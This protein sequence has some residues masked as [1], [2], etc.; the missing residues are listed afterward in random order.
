MK[1]RT[2]AVAGYSGRRRPFGAAAETVVVPFDAGHDPAGPDGAARVELQAMLDGVADGITVQDAAGRLHYAN[3]AAARIIGFETAAELLATPVAKIMQRF[4]LADEHGNPISVLDL[5]GRKALAGEPAPDLLVRYRILA[6]GEERWGLTKARAVRDPDGSIRLAVNVFTDIT[7]MRIAL[8]EREEWRLVVEAAPDGMIGTDAGGR[9]VLVNSE[10]EKLFGVERDRLMGRPAS[11]LLPAR[12]RSFLEEARRAALDTLAESSIVTRADLEGLRGDGTE[13]PIAVA[14]GRMVTAR[15]VVLLG[16][17]RDITE[18]RAVEER[19]AH[20]AFHDALT[21]L[22]NR[23]MLEQHLARG[24]ERAARRKGAVGLLYVDLDEFK[25]VNDSLGH[26]AGDFLLRQVGERLSAL[27][28]G[29]DLLARPGGDEFLLLVDDL[30]GD[31]AAAAEAIAERI[32]AALRPPF[33]IEGTELR[34]GASV[35]VSLFPDDATDAD[36]LLRHAD[37]ALYAG[38]AAGRGR[39]VS[40]AQ[41]AGP[42]ADRLTLTTR[43]RRAVAHEEFVLHW[44]PIVDLTDGR[45]AGAEGLVRWQDPDRGLLPPGEFIEAAEGLGLIGAIGE[46]VLREACRQAAAWEHRLPVSIN[47]SPRQVREPG[48]AAR[49]VERL[50]EAGLDTSLFTLELTESAAAEEGTSALTDLANVGFTIA[51][52]DFG[53]G[54]SSLAR[55]SALPVRELKIDRSFVA[56]LGSDRRAEAVVRAIVDLARSLGLEAVAEGIETAEQLRTLR[57]LGCRRGQGYLLGRPVA[58]ADLPRGCVTLP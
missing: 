50:R 24:L 58:A 2:P 42:D 8:R 40:Y 14:F 55:L 18:R 19:I 47:L 6:T 4:E 31:P 13:F 38:K 7:E 21:G 27:T 48:L 12:H 28:R 32:H 33:P 25:M 16:T 49:M 39:S 1:P 43:L 57:A 37:A 5:P 17:V 41:L 51:I 23:A 35:G 56:A 53:T 20:L 26:L 30:G 9:I 22:P 3:D 11:D 10:A 45:V 34:I 52:D 54:Y 44:Q 29:E 15:G 46:W 36:G